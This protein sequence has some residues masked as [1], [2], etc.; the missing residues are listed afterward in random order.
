MNKFI[1]IVITIYLLYYLGNILFDL[2][3]KKESNL[4]KEETEEFSFSEFSKNIENR[5]T[6]VGIEDVEKLNT[7]KSFIKS[8]R[9]FSE[10][11]DDS[12]KEIDIET[13]RKKFEAE[14]HI[15]NF[16]LPKNE[17]QI[18]NQEEQNKQ[19]NNSVSDLKKHFQS[20]LNL[21]ETSVQMIANQDGSRVYHSIL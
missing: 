5:T 6:E 8:D 11:N 19:S 9:Q 18:F 1:I 7:P 13:L 10:N 21:A 17:Q 3:L 12:E 14:E 4:L 20:L 16:E 2:F 15:E